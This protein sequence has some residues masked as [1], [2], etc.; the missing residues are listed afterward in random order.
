[1]PKK[2]LDIGQCDMDHGSIRQLIEDQFDARMVRT[3]GAED[4][5]AALRSQSFDLVLINRKLDRDQSDGVDIIR[6]IKSDS[7][8]ATVPVMLVTNFREHQEIAMAAGAEQ[9]FG[10]SA[11]RDEETRQRL[12]HVLGSEQADPTHDS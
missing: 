4:T 2:V 10:K 9:G 6:Q 1:M 5:I 8:L 7:E 12:S 3:H 11:L